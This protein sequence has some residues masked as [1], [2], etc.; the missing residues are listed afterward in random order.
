MKYTDESHS[1]IDDDLREVL[2]HERAK[3]EKWK[4]LKQKERKEE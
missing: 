1:F 3:Y 4:K 2:P